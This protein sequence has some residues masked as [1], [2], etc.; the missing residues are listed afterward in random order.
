MAG[1]K[2]DENKQTDFRLKTLRAEF[3]K[4]VED[5]ISCCSL[6]RRQQRWG[7]LVSFQS[8]P[9]PPVT[10]HIGHGNV[11]SNCTSKGKQMRKLHAV[12]VILFGLTFVAPGETVVTPQ[13]PK[14]EKSAHESDCP[15]MK[16]VGGMV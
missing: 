16:S 9:N 6:R 2:L 1:K 7:C 4:I 10:S 11:H 8:A 13:T 15:M 3:R 12:T 14:A 5:G